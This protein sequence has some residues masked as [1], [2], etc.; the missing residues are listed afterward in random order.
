MREALTRL[1]YSRYPVLFAEHRLDAAES[2]MAWG[3]QHGDGWFAIVDVNRP[4]FVGGP[5]D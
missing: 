2:G 4:G 3:F 5:T 1:L